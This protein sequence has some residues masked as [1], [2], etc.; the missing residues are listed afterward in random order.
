MSAASA[1][2]AAKP[3]PANAFKTLARLWPA[4]ALIPLRALIKGKRALYFRHPLATISG[5]T[6]IG[7]FAEIGAHAYINAG[8]DGV[9]IGSYSQ[10]NALTAIVGHVRIGDRVLIAPGCSIVAGGHRFGKGV[11]PRFSG[12]GG[13]KRIV[14][15][16]DV[17][18]GSGVTIVGQVTIG[19]GTVVAAGV[20][21][22]CDVPPETLVRRGTSTLVF[23]PMR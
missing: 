21:V 13:E 18:I 20:T 12:G 4:A 14:I 7:R 9:E 22:D 10:I 23:E 3:R 5:A 6:R 1:S 11:Q 8:P 16:D 17:W 19:R 2:D 15:E